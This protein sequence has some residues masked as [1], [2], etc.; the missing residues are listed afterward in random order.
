LTNFSNGTA[1]FYLPEF[2]YS[3]EVETSNLLL[4][5]DTF[6]H[7]M[8]IGQMSPLYHVVVVTANDRL[9]SQ[10]D[11]LNDFYVRKLEEY[12][13]EVRYGQTMT[14]IDKGIILNLR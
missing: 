13:V 5:L 9:I 4:A 2:P 3:G 12:G 6:K 8:N 11:L 14:A 10:S 7:F 1:V